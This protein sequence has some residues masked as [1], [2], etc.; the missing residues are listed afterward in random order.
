MSWA[1]G[2]VHIAATRAF[3]DYLLHSAVGKVSF[4][5]SLILF[6]FHTGHNPSLNLVSLSLYI[7]Y[8]LVNPEVKAI[9]NMPF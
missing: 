2:A 6:E 4:K 8:I 9:I 7:S 5:W 1:K 3:V